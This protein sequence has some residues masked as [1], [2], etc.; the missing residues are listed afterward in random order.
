MFDARRAI[1]FL[2][3]AFGCLR[4]PPPWDGTEPGDGDVDVDTGPRSDTDTEEDTATD[5][6]TADS[7]LKDTGEACGEGTIETSFD[8]ALVQ[9][10]PGESY[11]AEWPLT[12]DGMVCAVSCDTESTGMIWISA[13][14]GMTNTCAY[15]ELA[16]PADLQHGDVVAVCVEAS[17]P[18]DE[19]YGASCWL[20]TSSGTLTATFTIQE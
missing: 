7:E 17:V 13:W 2:L 18:A 5:T 15:T 10:K 9:L 20:E 16:I 6:D 8:G 3:V 19:R 4:P 11:A 1:P 14:L 12:G